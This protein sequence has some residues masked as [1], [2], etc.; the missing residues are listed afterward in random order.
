MIDLYITVY[1]SLEKIKKTGG[2][3]N[4]LPLSS[5]DLLAGGRGLF[6]RGGLNRGFTVVK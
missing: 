6:E 2:L 4:F 3:T 1:H 5:G